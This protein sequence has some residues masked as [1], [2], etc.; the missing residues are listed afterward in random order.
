[1][2]E[3][4]YTADPIDVDGEPF[5]I[6]GLQTALDRVRDTWGGKHHKTHSVSPAMSLGGGACV[7][8]VEDGRV[9]L[10]RDDAARALSKAR[11]VS[12]HDPDGRMRTYTAKAA[13]VLVGRA[14]EL[15]ATRDVSGDGLMGLM[16]HFALFVNETLGDIPTVVSR[17]AIEQRERSI[18]TAI[19]RARAAGR[20]ASV[21]FPVSQAGGACF[22]VPSQ[23]GRFYSASLTIHVSAPVAA[24][25]DV[26]IRRRE[27]NDSQSN[28]DTDTGSLQH[29][30]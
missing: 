6:E 7:L 13:I 4:F 29:E 23:P 3:R 9:L 2:P 10:I 20:D 27:N 19:A 26:T 22:E 28:G 5:T 17:G 1:M 12:D 16:Y 18:R 8:S 14:S 24:S 21:H 11:E 30:G 15:V 25:D